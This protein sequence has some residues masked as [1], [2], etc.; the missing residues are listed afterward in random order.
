MEREKGFEP[1]TLAL[2]NS[3]R[4]SQ[5]D[6]RSHTATQARV[7]IEVGSAPPLHGETPRA[8]KRTPFATRLLPGFGPDRTSRTPGV[9]L[10]AEPLLSVRDVARA[11]GVCAATVYR[12][13]KDANLA[14]LRVLNSIRVL[15]GDLRAFVARRDRP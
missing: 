12:L 14:H 2:A 6:A 5:R 10:S 3:A 4:A 8:P 1:S 9:A 13:C 11:L 15:P 7:P